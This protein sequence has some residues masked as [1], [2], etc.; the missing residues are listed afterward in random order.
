MIRTWK[1]T[2][3]LLSLLIPDALVGRGLTERCGSMST[4][5]ARAMGIS[6]FKAA[7]MAYKYWIK[8]YHEVLDDP[9]MGT[10]TDR[11]WR[12]SIE[13]FLLAGDFGEDGALPPLRDMAYRLRV[14]EEMLESD[15]VEL[16]REGIV[17]QIEG[18]WIVEK[19]QERQSPMTSAEKMRRKRDEDKADKYYVPE[20]NE[21]S[22]TEQNR[23][24]NNRVDKDEITTDA[25]VARLLEVNVAPKITKELIE[26]YEPHFILEKIR[27]Y[28]FK[29][30]QIPTTTVGWLIASIKENYAPPLGYEPDPD[31]P[32][33]IR[34]RYSKYA[35]NDH[36][37]QEE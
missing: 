30:R 1:H 6:L 7:L 25:V 20:S 13:L 3:D 17:A 4:T 8:L 5:P 23:I 35:N 2:V 11:L 14:S 22:H 15:L 34:Q 16:A 24:D 27:R 9:K 32:D 29:K 21:S 26:E 19:F 12:R 33:V 37:H 28:K 18:Q 10:M 36:P 31:N